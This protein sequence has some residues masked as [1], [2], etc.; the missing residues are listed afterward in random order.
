MQRALKTP[1]LEAVRPPNGGSSLLKQLHLVNFRAFKDFTLTFGTGAF[2][3]GPN[4]AGKSTLLT[5]LRTAD[6]LLRHAYRRKPEGSAIDRGLSVICYPV[7][8]RDF[9]ALRDSL[10][11]EFGSAETRLELE[12]KSGARLTVVWPEE[13]DG[14]NDRDPFFYLTQ[15]SG[16]IVHNP[17]QAKSAFPPLGVIPIL[18]PVEHSEKLLDG[19][20][21]RQNVTGRLSSR[22]FRNQLRQLQSADE[23]EEFL[24]WARPWLGDLSF[25]RLGQHFS[26]DGY[27]VEAFF[28]ESG[29]R[30]P[31][32]IV[33]A[34]DGVQVWLQLLYHVYR[35]RDYDAIILDE[36]EVYLHPDLQ[37]HL[38]LLLEATG[39]QV[40]VATHSAEI[41]AEADGRMA[42]LIDRTRR[43]ASRPKAEADY[44]MLSAT[45]GT[46]FNLRLAKALRSRV[47]VFVEGNDMSIL[48]HFAKTLGLTALESGIGVT[49]IPLEGY[50]NW[51]QVEPFKWLCNELLP[52][53]LQTFVV[54]DRDYR[55]DQVRLDVM[56]SLEAASIHGHVWERKELES[57]LITVEVISRLSGV[58][59]SQVQDWLNAITTGME[60]D[61]FSRLLDE[62]LRAQVDSS[63]HAV[64]VTTAFKPEFDALWPD[65]SFR[66]HACPPKQVLSRLNQILQAEGHKAV[67]MTALARSHRKPEIPHEVQDLLTRIDGAAAG[68]G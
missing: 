52:N 11:F 64:S 16:Y 54:L 68:V 60:D 40:I 13:E 49:I 42:T 36:P 23:L 10:R 62:R 66:L 51:G 56:K 65:T 2:L 37:R 14:A 55:P 50:S 30:V 6:V 39:R 58:G 63:K 34:G 61:V 29:S 9:P 47:A 26:N 15:A 59:S 41:V 4:N 21:V 32:E 7:L 5:A 18:G 43:R 24:E 28:F 27:I 25:D 20:Y 22:H 12:W 35:V 48:R 33:W 19:E 3:V 44:E 8:L 38:V 53:A 57:Y 31:K 45:L 46:S 67:S 1:I 17:A